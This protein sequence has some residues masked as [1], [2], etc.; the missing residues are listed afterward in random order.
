MEDTLDIKKMESIIE[1][2]LFAMGEKVATE[3]ICDVIGMDKKTT[4]AI[5]NNMMYS[6]NRSARGLMIREIND[7][8]QLCSRPEHHE[9]VKKAFEP[10]VRQFLSQAALETLGIIAYEGP[11]TKAK[12]EQVRGVNSD[13]AVTRLVEK[14][15][16][17]EVGRLD[18]PGKPAIFE[19]T[20]EFYR[21]F[22]YGS[23]AELPVLEL[24][25]TPIESLEPLPEENIE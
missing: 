8:F 13:G 19:V 17:K 7:G 14:Q 6:Y 4:R 11:V 12:I 20:E 23:K 9:Y 2:L 10:K 15:L 18:T 21:S 25:N 1:A 5:M 22:G 16:I 3:T 24:Q